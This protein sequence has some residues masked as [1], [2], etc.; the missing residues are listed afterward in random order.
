MENKKGNGLVI[1]LIVLVLLLAV[2]GTLLLTGVIKSPFIEEKKCDEKKTTET[3]E[4]KKEVKET[5]YYQYKTEAQ[6]DADGE[7][8]GK[9]KYYE[10][11]LYKDGTA[12][13]D[14][15]Y[16]LDLIPKKGIYVE[17]D[18]YIIL[19]L[20]GDN[21]EC[22]EGNYEPKIADSCTETIVFIKDNGVLKTQKGSIYHFDIDNVNSSQEFLQVQK[23]DLQTSLKN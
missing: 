23:T 1:F 11:A 12:S 9:S 7:A 8:N 18:K 4:E 13:V 15:L 22:V 20:N 2:G 17:N 3:K 16:V 6:M 5:R 21:P 14:Y 19:A 10:I